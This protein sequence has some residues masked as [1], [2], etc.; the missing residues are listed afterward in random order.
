[1][2]YQQIKSADEREYLLTIFVG[3]VS[4]AGSLWTAD[5]SHAQQDIL[6]SNIDFGAL[7]SLSLQ[8]GFFES[9][10]DLDMECSLDAALWVTDGTDIPLTTVHLEYTTRDK[11][12]RKKNEKYKDNNNKNFMEPSAMLGSKAAALLSAISPG[13][14]KSVVQNLAQAVQTGVLQDVH[15]VKRLFLR[16]E[17]PSSMTRFVVAAPK[18]DYS[19]G[20]RES[21]Q[22][23]YVQSS[24]FSLDL[25]D[26]ENCVLDT[27]ISID[28]RHIGDHSQPCS[29][30]SPYNSIRAR[31]ADG[32]LTIDIGE[33]LDEDSEFIDFMLDGD[34]I[35]TITIDSVGGWRCVELAMDA[36]WATMCFRS[37]SDTVELIVAAEDMLVSVAVY[38]CYYLIDA[39][40][41]SH[42][43][44]SPINLDDVS[45]SVF[46][47][48]CTPVQLIS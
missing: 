6:V 26:E 41:C 35:F 16:D 7:R 18:F 25:V 13:S 43:P 19:I 42:L 44:I 48:P 20:D 12:K 47:V 22:M 46:L 3:D 34:H 15:V 38:P 23:W 27:V 2:V 37:D 4:V 39:V 29:L 32:S 40:L 45:L 31:T 28:C 5:P 10:F 17:L 36:R 1:M 24:G 9:Q 33:P 21:N 11:D 8:Y 14:V 30:S